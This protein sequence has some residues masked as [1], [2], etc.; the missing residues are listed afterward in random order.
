MEPQKLD[1]RRISPTEIEIYGNFK[2]ND[3]VTFKEDYFP[4]WRAYENG[5]EIPLAASNHEL[6]LVNT[7]KGNVIKLIY[8]VLPVEKVYG[9]LSLLSILLLMVV[10]VILL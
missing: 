4:R 1:F 2:D 5:K 3:W 6:I 10:F 9:I 7:V 8:S